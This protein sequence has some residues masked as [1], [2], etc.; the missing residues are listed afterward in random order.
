M[1]IYVPGSPQEFDI[2]FKANYN[3]NTGYYRLSEQ[4]HGM[5]INDPL[6]RNTIT[7]TV[8]IAV[9]PML[10]N[11]Y[12]ATLDMP[13]VDI[14][15]YNTIQPF[16]SDLLLTKHYDTICIVSP[17]YCGTMT[18]IILDSMTGKK[19]KLYDFSIPKSNEDHYG[20]YSQHESYYG[21]DVKSLGERI[22]NI[23]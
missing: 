14:I 13:N 8:I 16:S 9:G 3:K 11:V 12:E 20:T 5:I 17:F 15:Y 4:N 10:R 6:I 2:L 21:L 1:H 18:S 7:K 22:R 23:L 19:Y